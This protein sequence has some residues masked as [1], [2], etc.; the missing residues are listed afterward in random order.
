M[1]REIKKINFV[2][3]VYKQLEEHII[4]GQWPLETKIPSENELCK[5]FNVSRNTVRSAIDKLKAIGM[6]V[7]RQG[8]GTFVNG[9]LSNSFSDGF[10]P[11]M[12]LDNDE[13]L[14]IL[15]FRRMVEA[16]AAECAAVRASQEDIAKIEQA[17]EEM[18]KTINDP[19]EY[20]IA[21]YKFHFSIAEA[22]KNRVF[23][24]IMY[25]LKDII[26]NNLK[27]MNGMSDMSGLTPGLE[28]HG[29]ILEAIKM[30]DPQLARFLITDNLNININDIKH[31]IYFK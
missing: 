14:E 21:D 27:E 30:K 31:K 29:K 5:M 3:E 28:R 7:S 1:P 20:S 6:L 18:C 19:D 2:D 15:E 16:E 8:Q 4:S 25:R 13:T 26:F 9:S 23:I 17:Y 10:I 12:S 24:R 11:A 22:S